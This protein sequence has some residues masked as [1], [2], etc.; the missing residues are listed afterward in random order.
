MNIP[1]VC[2]SVYLLKVISIEVISWACVFI[3]FGTYQGVRPLSFLVNVY[4]TLKKLPVSKVIIPFFIP[5]S[6]M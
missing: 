2:L 4:L 6:N 3:S 1:T 5:N